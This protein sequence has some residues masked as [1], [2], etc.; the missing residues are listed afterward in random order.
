M[1]ELKCPHCGQVFK[2]DEADYASIL[3]Q[4]KNSEFEAEI[5][6]RLKELEEKHKAEQDL[7][8]AKNEKS[9]QAQLSKKELEISAK[10]SEIDR[11]RIE[12]ESQLDKVKRE[13]D[14]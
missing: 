7:A 3:S 8:A 1:K 9:F 6:R 11:L 10:Q 5:S 14:A 13:K 2:V 12:T 4:V